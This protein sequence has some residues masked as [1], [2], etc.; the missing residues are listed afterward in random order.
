MRIGSDYHGTSN[1]GGGGGYEEPSPDLYDAILACIE[2]VGL[3][4]ARDSHKKDYQACIIGL[5]LV[6]TAAGEQVRD[7]KGRR[8]IVWKD[9]KLDLFDGDNGKAKPTTLRLL[10]DGLKPGRVKELLAAGEEPDT[11]EW[12]GMPVRVMV[13][14]T[15]TGKA[16]AKAFLKSK[17]APVATE[18]D[19]AQP[20]G[21]WK[22]LIGRSK[23]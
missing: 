8:F 9:C 21:L 16:K 23:G 14:H 19:Y 11:D 1:G 15:A 13:E 12:V 2:P 10:L 4:P 6:Q 3:Q 7:S 18:R 20:F 22:Y 17:M 5:E